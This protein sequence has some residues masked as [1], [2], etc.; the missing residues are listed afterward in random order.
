MQGH[1]GQ[2]WKHV[3]VCVY[4]RPQGSAVE[5]CVCVLDTRPQGPA[6]ETCVCVC[7]LDTRPQGSAVETCV[8]VLDA[9]PQ[10]P[11][12][13]HKQYSEVVTKQHVYTSYTT[14]S[15]RVL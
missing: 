14:M 10:G 9:R 13:S 5:T 11:G 4:S 7:V 6:V 3:C 2:P 15:R 12:E 8:C 1:K